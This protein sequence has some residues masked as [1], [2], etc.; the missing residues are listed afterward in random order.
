MSDKSFEDLSNQ[1]VF[2]SGSSI[3]E[4][5]SCSETVTAIQDSESSGSFR[6]GWD[7]PDES[8]LPNSLVELDIHEAK[9]LLESFNN[10]LTD[11]SFQLNTP[12]NKDKISREEEGTHRL[13]YSEAVSNFTSDVDHKDPG[14]FLPNQDALGGKGK[15]LKNVFEEEEELQSGILSR[16]VLGKLSEM[17]KNAEERELEKLSYKDFSSFF[18]PERQNESYISFKRGGR[19]FGISEVEFSQFVKLSKKIQNSKNLASAI[20]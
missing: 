9:T 18:V 19:G 13:S 4:Q 3:S 6:G 16:P 12:R 10:S 1:V 11:H 17:I 2:S 14:D 15:L 7:S 20:F 8:S 5:C